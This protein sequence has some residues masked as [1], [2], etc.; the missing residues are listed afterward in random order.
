MDKRILGRTGLS[1]SEI[2]FGGVEIGMPYGL[3]AQDRPSDDDAVRLLSASRRTRYQ[4]LRYRTPLW[5]KRK[6][7]GRSI[8]GYTKGGRDRDQ[9]RTP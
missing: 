4:F 8:R 5:R 7:D 9:V 2:A 3:G 1:V 6:A